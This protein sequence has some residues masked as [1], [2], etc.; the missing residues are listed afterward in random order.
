MHLLVGHTR[1]APP[2][3]GAPPRGAGAAAAA[4]GAGTA[5]AAAAA[6]GVP[7]G[8]GGGRGGDLTARARRQEGQRGPRAVRPA[9]ARPLMRALATARAPLDALLQTD[10]AHQCRART[11]RAPARRFLTEDLPHPRSL[12]VPLAPRPGRRAPH[13]RGAALGA[14]TGPRMYRVA[15]TATVAR[16]TLPLLLVTTVPAPA[17]ERTD[18]GLCV[19]FCF[20]RRPAARCPLLPARAECRRGDPGRFSRRGAPPAA[21]RAQGGA[22]IALSPPWPRFQARPRSPPLERV[23]RRAFARFVVA[24]LM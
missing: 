16:C 9:G 24:A 20:P 10:A 12:R 11:S 23:L 21:A 4:A 18:G 22:G 13:A 19:P 14:S 1:D 2:L 17:R 15:C 3:D 6:A 7:G 8:V 5:A